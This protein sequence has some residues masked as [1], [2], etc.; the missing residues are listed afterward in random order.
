M[1]RPLNASLMLSPEG[2]VPDGLCGP[3]RTGQDRPYT[4]RSVADRELLDACV[5]CERSLSVLGWYWFDCFA[6][7]VIRPLAQG[8]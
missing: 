1:L 3:N 4:A 7:V 6:T 5:A 8:G 2:L